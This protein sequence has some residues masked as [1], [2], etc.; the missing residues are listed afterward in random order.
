MH[1]LN[2]KKPTLILSLYLYFI[3]I[4]NHLINILHYNVRPNTAIFNARSIK[5]VFE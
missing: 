1:A 2:T 3:L 5:Y 4:K